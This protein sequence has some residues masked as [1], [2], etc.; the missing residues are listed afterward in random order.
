MVFGFGPT[1]RFYGLCV[2]LLVDFF[3]RLARGQYT[4]PAFASVFSTMPSSGVV[5]SSG[6]LQEN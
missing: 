1:I 4:Y 2:T 3:L 6:A 5:G